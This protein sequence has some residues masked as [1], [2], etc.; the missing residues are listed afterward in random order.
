MGGLAGIRTSRLTS[1][2]PV[3]PRKV[4]GVRHTRV[5]GALSGG[6]SRDRSNISGLDDSRPFTWG[7]AAG[8]LPNGS[9]LESI[10]ANG[11]E[12]TSAPKSSASS[13]GQE[14]MDRK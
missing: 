5:G 2:A 12:F 3:G 13:P 9:A 1:E 14:K 6:A 8:S 11:S 10:S 4:S 7:L